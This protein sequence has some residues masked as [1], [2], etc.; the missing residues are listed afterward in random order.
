M[1]AGGARRG[2]RDN[3]LD[4]SEYAVAGDVD[5]RI[6]EHLLD[7]LAAGGIAAYLQPSAD[8][9]PVTR[10]TTVPSRPVDRLYVDR[11]HL[12]TARDY[13]TQLTDEA[14]T[15]RPRPD[16][17][18]IEAE[19][20]RIVAGFHATPTAGDNPWPAAEDVDPDEPTK[21][22]PVT[23]TGA[24]EPGGPTATDVRRLPY[25]ADISG[26]S[27]GPDRQDEPSLLDGLDTF[28]AD[29]PDDEDERYT[30]PPPPPLP[31]ISK[32][33]AAG[34]LAIVVGFLLFLFP[35]LLPV[36]RAVVTLFGFTGILAGFVTLIWRLRP[37]D[38][39]DDDPDDGAVV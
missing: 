27:V 31:R 32:Y 1:S 5:P 14:P 15:D 30:P 11:S 21:S 28:G 4:A 39:D 19:W 8:L 16:E 20:A 37:G 18:D 13:L 33:A 26:I 6:G 10:T 36:D 29:L 12:T 34:V 9:N 35:D 17:P 25:A 24:D 3:G 7:V 2:R 22:G 38:S 23:R